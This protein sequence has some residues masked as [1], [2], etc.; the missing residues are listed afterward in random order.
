M[1]SFV[2]FIGVGGAAAALYFGL[3]SLFVEL[4]RWNYKAGVSA[5]YVGA[6]S[7]H[8]FANR[9]FTFQ[10][11]REGVLGQARRFAAVALINYAITMAI[12]Y[13]SVEWLGIGVYAGTLLSVAATVLFGYAASRIWVFQKKESVPR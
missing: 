1:Q 13:A 6:I 7:F 9:H 12:V 2:K 3:L 4:L 11:G 10:A 5:A 8:F